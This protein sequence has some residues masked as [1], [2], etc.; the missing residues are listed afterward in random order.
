MDLSWRI[1]SSF[2]TV[3][4]RLLPLHQAQLLAYLSSIVV[5]LDY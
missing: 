3:G 2:E 1:S 4:A 5:R